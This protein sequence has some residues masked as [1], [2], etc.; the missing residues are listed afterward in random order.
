MVLEKS[1]GLLYGAS[2]KARQK[3]IALL[4]R[5]GCYNTLKFFVLKIELFLLTM[6]G[7]NEIMLL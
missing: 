7:R 1:L 2:L 3:N 4:S 6:L 5:L